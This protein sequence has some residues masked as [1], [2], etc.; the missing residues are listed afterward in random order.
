MII[1]VTVIL[2]LF[3]CSTVISLIILLGNVK[4]LRETWVTRLKEKILNY[5][6]LIIEG[7]III[8]EK[9]FDRKLSILIKWIVPIL[10]LSIVSFCLLKF[11]QY[12]WYILP[13]NIITNPLHQIYIAFSI[14]AVYFTYFMATFTDPGVI[15]YNNILKYGSMFKSNDLIF[16]QDQVCS[17]CKFIKPARSKH[18]STCDNCVALFDHHC[19]FINN[20]VGYRNYGF[21]MSFLLTNIN[22]LLYGGYICFKAL[23]NVKTSEMSYWN[24]IARTNE[25][26][27]ITG[28]LMFLGLIFSVVVTVF[29]GMHLRYIYL[30]ITT[31]ELEKWKDIEHLVKLGVLYEILNSPI[32]Q[33]RFVEKCVL[34]DETSSKVVF[35][36]LKDEKVLFTEDDLHDHNIRAI[37]SVE[38]DLINIYDRGLWNNIKERMFP[39]YAVEGS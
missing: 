15:R 7:C 36:S 34:E 20:C 13:Q 31:N 2:W 25:T 19:V 33:E 10:Y 38:D 1:L 35:I 14:I 21:F 32:N 23:Q 26:N 28:I 27:K 22:F 9:Y 4:L 18:C 12:T 30:G 11:F 39:S 5:I 29:T 8:N 17:T 3:A 16:F 24:I 6:N 37:K